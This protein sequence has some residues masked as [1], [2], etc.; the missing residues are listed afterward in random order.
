[1]DFIR[2]Q[3]HYSLLFDVTVLPAANYGYYYRITEKQPALIDIRARARALCVREA[4]FN[5]LFAKDSPHVQVACSGCSNAII[6]TCYRK[7]GK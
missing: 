7:A 2:D 4:C 3:A 1:M 5:F 6:D